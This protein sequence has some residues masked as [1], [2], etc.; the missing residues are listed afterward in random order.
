M[1]VRNEYIGWQIEWPQR[2]QFTLSHVAEDEELWDK[3][4]DFVDEKFP[5][6]D[7]FHTDCVTFICGFES[8]EDARL[9]ERD[10][11]RRVC[12]WINAYT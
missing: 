6:V 3:L 5:G 10:L 12:Y 7:T 2:M 8:M 1:V 11:T 4:R 9:F